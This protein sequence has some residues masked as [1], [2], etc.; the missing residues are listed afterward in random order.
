MSDLNKMVEKILSVRRRQLRTNTQKVLYSLLK[1]PGKWVA[2][3]HFRV[4]STGSRL[5]DLRT[6]NF[7]NLPVKCAH[8]RQLPTRRYSV[9]TKQPT[10]YK[11][12][13]TDISLEI[14]DEI[15]G[16]IL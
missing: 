7:G 11:L 8:A 15:F 5:R 13:L 4:P 1:S 10:F 12:E 14:L 3:V 16:E 2:R 9:V 6:E